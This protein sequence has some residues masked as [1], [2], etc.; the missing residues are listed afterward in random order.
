MARFSKILVAN[1][2]EIAARIIRS[3]RALGYR[4]VAVHSAADAGAPHVALADEAVEIGPAPVGE[5]YLSVPR[6]LEAAALTGADALHP[7]Y[8]FLAENAEF[9]A[10]CI[11]AGLTFIGP[12]PAAIQA[13]GNKREAKERAAAAGVPCLPGLECRGLDQAGIL[14]VARGLGL[15]LMVK[16]AAGGGG[17]GLRFVEREADLAPALALAAA[18]AQSAFG[19]G[20]LILERAVL[21]GRHVEVQV[22]ADTHGNCLHLGER[23]CSV[24]RRHQKIIE[25]APSPAVDPAL[26]AA[27]GQA[28]VRLAHAVGYVGAGTVEFLLD[29][30]GAFWFL[31]MNTRLQVEHPVTECVTGLDLVALQIE[32]AAGARLPL[33]QDEVALRGHAIE[34]RLYAEDPRQGFLPQT[35]PV[36]VFDPPAG[37]GL[38][39]DAGILAGQEV[40][41]FYDPMLA[42]VI[43]HGRDREEARRRLVRAL[44]EL[45]LLGPTTN[46]DF[47]LG[48]LRD[49]VFAGGQATTDWVDHRLAMP[50]APPPDDAAWALAAVLLEGREGAG[51]GWWSAGRMRRPLRLRH[52]ETL[53]HARIAR[54]EGH[55][56]VSLG[57]GAAPPGD[58]ALGLA[59]A[60]LAREGDRLRFRIGPVQATAR[61]AFDGEALLLDLGGRVL[62][63]EPAPLSDARL[64]DGAAGGEVLAPMSGRVV[65]VKVTAGEQ[66]E[67]G[68]ALLVLEAMKMHLAVTAAA[69]GKVVELRVAEGEQV[70]PRQLLARLEVAETV[71]A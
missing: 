51:Q 63:F 26:R 6:L 61:H 37:P 18:E 64:Q 28:A 22:F 57:E 67:K 5:S 36:L 45:A 33:A 1:R 54:T 66:V 62:R 14:A 69:A 19:D 70:R 8:G 42:K 9:A 49:P 3:A 29:A 23:D 27:M 71:G 13:M 55:L 24:Q 38:R 30:E 10:A 50:P 68:A 35:G 4:T 21:S 15:P 25:E 65:A 44:E 47:L 48:I 2:G 40:T 31:E 20:E 53:R 7:G 59:V 34:A 16:A 56:A 32:V 52:G 43:A 17:R 39:V 11:A 60:L 58:D 12:P 41:A 46:R